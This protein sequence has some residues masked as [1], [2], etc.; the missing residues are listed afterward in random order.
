MENGGQAIEIDEGYLF[1]GDTYNPEEQNQNIFL[2]RANGLGDT[3]WTKQFGDSEMDYGDDIV[4]TVD[5]GYM[6]LG[7]TKQFSILNFDIWMIK[8][9]TDGIEQWN[10]YHGSGSD[11]YGQTILYLSA[12]SYTHLTLPTIYSV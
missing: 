10:K 1:I 5:G 2:I 7:S 6:I 3:L 11:D 12:V 4:A 8:I 9:D